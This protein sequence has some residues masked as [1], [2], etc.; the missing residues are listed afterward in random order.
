MPG[1]RVAVI[2]E[3]GRG[4][5]HGHVARCSAVCDAFS[6]AGIEPVFIVDGDAGVRRA[7]GGRRLR[8]MDWLSDPEPLLR[9]IEGFDAALVDSYHAPLKLY[10][11]IEERVGVAAYFDDTMRLDY[12][13]GIVINADADAGRLPYACKPGRLLLLGSAY[14][15]L[16]KAF[17]SARSRQS[18]K[19]F[20]DIL[21]TLGG[22]DPRRLLPRVLSGLE[23]FPEL[24]A[25]VVRGGLS[26]AAMKALMLRCDAAVSAGGQTLT[27]LARLGVPAAVVVAADNQLR[28]AAGW[29]KAGFALDAGRWDSPD[30]EGSV[31]RA[32]RR[33]RDRGVRVRMAAR[34]RAMVDGKGARRIVSSICGCLP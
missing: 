9:L 5:G 25:H 17:W 8:L 31:A 22:E 20:S 33:L 11:R 16:R 3:G 4:R 24:R 10:A 34:G 26:Q 6:E 21:V 19:R 2:A 28:H 7:A 18:R 13:P 23:R 27:E 1:R 32:V 12:P 30:L 14:A 29:R 15:P